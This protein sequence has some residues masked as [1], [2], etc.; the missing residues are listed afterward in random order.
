MLEI[1][2]SPLQYHFASIVTV[3][4]STVLLIPMRSFSFFFSLSKLYLVPSLYP[5]VLKCFNTMPHFGTYFPF[6]GWTLTEQSQSKNALFIQV[7]EIYCPFF[8]FHFSVEHKFI[9]EMLNLPDLS[10]LEIFLIYSTLF[11]FHGCFNL[12]CISGF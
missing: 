4:E 2:R 3:E 12:S 9:N 7:N 6:T 11:L 8:L 5:M 1:L 10:F